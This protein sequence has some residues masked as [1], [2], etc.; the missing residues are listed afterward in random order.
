MPKIIENLQTKILDESKKIIEESGI[1]K[2]SIRKLASSLN[3]APSTIYNYY[4]SK[5][6]IV[7]ALFRRNWGDALTR[8]DG[9]C[10]D[11]IETQTAM[12]AIVRELRGGVRPLLHH[13]VSTMTQQKEKSKFDIDAALILPLE[14]RVTT[15][16]VVN[17]KTDAEADV[18]APILTKLILTCTND[19]DIE[20]KDIIETVK[21]L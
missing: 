16:L 17:G 15:I 10:E 8:I 2:L 4:E 1:D 14:K 9:I 7:E 3:I 21:G 5:D 19:M 12:E 20:F 11:G 13:Y 6:Q 18:M